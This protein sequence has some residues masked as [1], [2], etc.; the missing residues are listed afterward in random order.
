MKPMS[1]RE[2]GSVLVLALLATLMGCSEGEG[3]STGQAVAAPTLQPALVPAGP[4]G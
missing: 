4:E 1:K 3:A 2:S